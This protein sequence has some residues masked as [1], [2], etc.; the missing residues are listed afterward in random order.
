MSSR[1]TGQQITARL[2]ASGRRYT[3]GRRRVV[4][5]LAAADG[6]KSAS[7]LHGGLGGK[8]PV[9][10]LYR[11]LAVLTEAGVLAPHHGSRGGIRYELAEWLM[12]HHHHLV[13]TR[14]GAVGDV[15]LPEAWEAALTALASDAAGLQGFTA[16][17]HTLEIGGLC[18]DCS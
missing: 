17:G 14:C 8:V 18:A 15:E 13:C 7:E 9:S 4:Q 16:A 11:S 6:P 12:G 5:F 3:K 2:A 1:Q 10:S